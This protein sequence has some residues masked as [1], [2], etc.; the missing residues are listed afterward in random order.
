MQNV[1]HIPVHSASASLPQTSA[2]QNTPSHPLF[3]QDVLVKVNIGV[4]KCGFSLIQ[5]VG[6]WVLSAR[7]LVARDG[8]AGAAM[9]GFTAI[10]AMENPVTG[11]GSK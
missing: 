2:Y 8:G 11:A 5:G 9:D 3:Q 7:T 10:L 4:T 6:Y 1:T